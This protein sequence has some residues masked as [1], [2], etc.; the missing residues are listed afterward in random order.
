MA[1]SQITIAIILGIAV[2]LIVSITLFVVKSAQTTQTAQETTK[3]QT[4]APEVKPIIQHITACLEST[5]A[6][7]IEILGQQGGYI[8]REQGGM[9]PNPRESDAGAL[10]VPFQGQKVSYGISYQEVS[11]PD[12]PSLSSPYGPDPEAASSS[13]IVTLPPLNGSSF[14]FAYQLEQYVT[15]SI[16]ECI[17]YEFFGKKGFSFTK[18]QKY[19]HAA[20]GLER[21]DVTL[22]YPLTIINN[23]T[24]EQLSVDTFQTAKNIRFPTIH[25]VLSSLLSGDVSSLSFNLSTMQLPEGISLTVLPDA[26]NQDDIIL[27]TD[28]RSTLAG[29]AYEIRIA[30]HNRNPAL[31]YLMP[32]PMESYL[33]PGALNFS[34]NTDITPDL[35]TA[36]LGQ[37]SGDDP[38]EDTITFSFTVE[39]RSGNPPLPQS[40]NTPDMEVRITASDGEKEDYQTIV[41]V[42]N[43]INS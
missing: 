19:A 37:P 27:L 24:R 18:G 35:L 4:T 17:D 39:S 10:F 5:S 13:G 8:F 33:V 31:H 2:L 26:Y 1:R 36:Y 30:R 3:I 43:P 7:A 25:A 20:L 42:R 11:L 28:T 23:I 22:F 40:L 34:Q 6:A 16:D 32:D 14:S 38:D 12:Y 41:I 21:I 29:K 15:S 9:F